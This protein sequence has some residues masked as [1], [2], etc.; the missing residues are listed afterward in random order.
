MHPWRSARQSGQ[1]LF[2]CNP[3]RR[4]SARQ[5]RA[6]AGSER[7]PATGPIKDRLQ[8]GELFHGR[9]AARKVISRRPV[10]RDD[11]V[12]K[13]AAIL[14]RNGTLVAL[15]RKLILLRTADVPGFGH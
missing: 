5:G 10:E 3:T 4:R 13:E 1:T 2:P 12:G 14:R 11:Q 9:V 7:P 8:S 15:K 6:V